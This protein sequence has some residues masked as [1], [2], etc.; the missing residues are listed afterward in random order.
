MQINEQVRLL[1][2]EL[3]KKDKTIADIK[4]KSATMAAG[5]KKVIND[6]LAQRDIDTQKH[7]SELIKAEANYKGLLEV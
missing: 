3:E 1:Q 7:K 6:L 4:L 5:Y 2:Q